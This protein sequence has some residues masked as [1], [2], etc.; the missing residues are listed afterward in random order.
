M[1]LD[2][3]DVKPSVITAVIVFLMVAIT[4]PLAKFLMQKFPIPGISDVIM[5][6]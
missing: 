6:I 5:S 1:N 4:V 2:L 3:A